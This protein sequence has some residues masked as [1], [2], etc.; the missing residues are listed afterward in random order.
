MNMDTKFS[1]N[2]GGGGG[3]P[4]GKGGGNNAS[5]R[6]NSDLDALKSRIASLEDALA[7]TRNE[8]ANYRTQRNDA[9]DQISKLQQDY[10]KLEGKIK[11]SKLVQRAAV[12]HSVDVELLDGVLD[13]KHNVYEMDPNGTDTFPRIQQLTMET[14]KKHPQIKLYKPVSVGAVNDIPNSV[15]MKGLK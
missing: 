8:A 12:M 9:K 11:I 7:K 4:K 5:T 15:L 6:D 13:T 14:V 10:S 3:G 2:T 1:P